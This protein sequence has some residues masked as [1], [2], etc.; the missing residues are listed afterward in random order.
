MV[1]SNC[2]YFTTDHLG[3][4]SAL[5]ATA[6]RVCARDDFLHTFQVARQLLPARMPAAWLA[7]ISVILIR[8]LFQRFAFA[9]GFN[10]LARYTR[11][12]I[13]RL[14]LQVAHRLAALAARGDTV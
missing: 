10:L 14:E 1:G 7:E 6:L 8:P 2:G 4:P 13:Q 9:L 5:T 3:L 11:P 12:R